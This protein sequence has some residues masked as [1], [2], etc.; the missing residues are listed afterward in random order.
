M[1][2]RTYEIIFKETIVIIIIIIICYEIYFQ[3]RKYNHQNVYAIT[4]KRSEF[5][6]D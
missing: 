3:K 1:Q 2:T 6:N 4:F 5:K